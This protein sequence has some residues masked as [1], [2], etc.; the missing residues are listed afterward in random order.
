MREKLLKMRH[1]NKKCIKKSFNS[2]TSPP[3]LQQLPF[4]I[5]KESFFSYILPYYLYIRREFY[6]LKRGVSFV[7]LGKSISKGGEDV[8]GGYFGVEKGLRKVT[9]NAI[10][11]S[12]KLSIEAII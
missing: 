7:V 11:S 2:R 9:W 1:P 4:S 12:I 6:S 5:F 8:L 10:K 3:P